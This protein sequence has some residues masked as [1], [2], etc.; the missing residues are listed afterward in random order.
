[1]CVA[2]DTAANILESSDLTGGSAA[3][4]TSLVDT[5]PSCGT[6]LCPTAELYAY[7]HHGTRVID[8]GPPGQPNA[9]IDVQLTGNRLTWVNDGVMHETNLG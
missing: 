4:S 1:M 9:L 6:T 5:P 7:D 2:G 3:W 8:S